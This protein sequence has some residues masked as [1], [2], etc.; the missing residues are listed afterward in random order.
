MSTPKNVR[1]NIGAPFPALVKASG[2]VTIKKQNGIW[3]AGLSFSGLGQLP[4]AV[5]PTQV[6]ILVYNLVAGTFQIT[7]LAGVQSGGLATTTVTHAMSP[8]AP[9]PTDFYLLVDTTGGAVEIDLPLAATRGG[10]ALTIKDYKGNAA[11]SNITIKPQGG[12]AP[13]TVDNYTNGAP[14]VLQANYDG[15]KLLPIAS[16]YVVSP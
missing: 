6:Q 7:T 4:V 13:E 10:V 5:N 2:P 11:A 15:V 14:L 16:G 1:V 12:G 8:Y 9:L 3:T